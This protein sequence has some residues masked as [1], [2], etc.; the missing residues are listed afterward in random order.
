MLLT[1]RAVFS[2]TAAVA[3]PRYG[4]AQTLTIRIGVLNDQSGPYRGDGGPTGA[5]CTKQALADFG[6]SG[7]GWN[8]EVVSADHQNKPDV[9]VSIIRQRIDQDGMDAIFDVPTS[10]VALAVNTVCREK[11]KQSWDIAKVIATTP[12]DEAWQPLNEGGCPLVQS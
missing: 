12:M 7:K 6:I 2:A 3:M 8:V 5:V 11:T 1:R 4:F 10:S 9:G